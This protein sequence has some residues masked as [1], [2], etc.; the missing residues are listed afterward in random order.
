MAAFWILGTL[1]GRFPFL[2]KL[3]ADGGYQGPVISLHRAEEN[4]APL[5]RRCEESSNDARNTRGW[6]RGHTQHRNE[7]VDVEHSPGSEDAAGVAKDI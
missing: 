1:F 4:L 7:V 6:L 3:F 5:V 2:K